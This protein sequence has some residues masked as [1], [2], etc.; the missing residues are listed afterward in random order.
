M[1]PRIKVVCI[2][3]SLIFLGLV[4]D[5]VRRRVLREGY[6]LLWIAAALVLLT[7]SIFNSLLFG[8]AR[9][10]HVMDANSLLF[11]GAFLFVCIMLIHV[12]LELSRLRRETKEL[13]QAQALTE[14]RA[15]RA[16]DEARFAKPSPEGSADC[17]SDE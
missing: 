11:A 12:S 15:R 8:V 6:S 13:A 16:F 1:D 14:W 17:E 5:L 7:I 10:L 3:A 9:W 2:A 4:V